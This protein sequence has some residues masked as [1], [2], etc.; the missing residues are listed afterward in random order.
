MNEIA[1]NQS[2]KEVTLD[3]DECAWATDAL[4]ADAVDDDDDDYQD[5]YYYEANEHSTL[6]NWL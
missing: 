3:E 1:M 6:A 5:N 2:R 4:D